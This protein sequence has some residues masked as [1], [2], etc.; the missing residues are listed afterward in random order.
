MGDFLI[1]LFGFSQLTLVGGDAGFDN[2]GRNGA[3]LT[4][5]FWLDC[6]RELGVESSTFFLGDRQFNFSASGTAADAF[7][8]A[9]PFTN[10]STGVPI[11][12]R[13][14]VSFPA[15]SS[16]QRMTSLAMR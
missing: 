13:E 1:S 2:Q 5:G 15:F 12:D 14:I 6:E 9:R 4:L 16:L 3:R 10:I 11:P 8:L 7:V